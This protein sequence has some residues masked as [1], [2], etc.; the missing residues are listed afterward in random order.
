MTPA[1]RI[2]A[3]ITLLDEVARAPRRPA[4][5]T[6][7][8]FFRAR[9]YIGG[10][11]RRAIAERSWSILRQKLRLDW[12]I[13]KRGTQAT[14]R[15]L[16]V[17]HLLLAEHWS[18]QEVQQGFSGGRFNPD[19]LAVEEVSVLRA[20]AQG[21]LIQPEM[22]ESVVL[23]V[24]EWAL[25]GY[26]QRF[27]EEL[28]EAAAAME[29]PA[30]LDLRANLLR[31]T[32]DEAAKALAAEGIACEPMQ[33][34]PWGLRIPDRRP[35]LNSKA[36]KEGWVEIQDE[37]SQLIALLT[38]ASPGMR[39]A[40]YCAGAAGKTLAMASMMQNRGRI[41]A[42]DVSAIRLEGASARLRR[43]GVNNAE[44]H[45]LTPGDRWT[46]RR[47]EQ[48][49]V[50]LVDAPCTGSGTWRRNPDARTR[51]ENRDLEEL[52]SK[53]KAILDTAGALVRPGGRLVYATC[54]VLPEEDSMQVE[55]FLERRPDFAPLPL[56][57]VWA[58]A[59]SGSNAPSP[60][61]PG[62]WLEL[63]PHRHNTD[64]FFAGVLKRRA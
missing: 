39:V 6:A 33:Y 29:W 58:G 17:A 18:E 37:G 46:K 12:H 56:E 64:G 47:R 49:D 61:C 19:P 50:V 16:V 23:N 7:N 38:G 43:A 20:L 25:P 4:D 27:G 60:P 32:R 51:T 10:G 62:P 14:S 26:R 45:L 40:D 8:A 22:P 30:P 42:C 24:P 41:I 63:A 21:R 15:L 1:A 36:F 34:S 54:S 35:I 53:Q 52:V 57:E 44:C 5:A 28:A 31:C 11:D 3:T 2:A 13:E 55:G 59:W 48:F 9:R